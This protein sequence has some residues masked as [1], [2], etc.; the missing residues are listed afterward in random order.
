MQ[1]EEITQI[2][3]NSEKGHQPLVYENHGVDA[4]IRESSEISPT[5]TAVSYTHLEAV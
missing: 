1:V 4:R 2:F 5:V 3:R